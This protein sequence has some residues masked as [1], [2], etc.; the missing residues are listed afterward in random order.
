MI[1]DRLTYDEFLARIDPSTA[2]GY[3]TVQE[4][5]RPGN[6]PGRSDLP[7]TDITANKSGS[8]YAWRRNTRPTEKVSVVGSQKDVTRELAD[9]N[10]REAR[11]NRMR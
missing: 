6:R 4:N 5:N 11:S 7:I 8:T 1:G 10:G 3:R 9:K 2:T